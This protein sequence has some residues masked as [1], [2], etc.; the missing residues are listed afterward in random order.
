[1][2]KALQPPSASASRFHRFQAA[3]VTAIPGRAVTH[4]CQG[5]AGAG[6]AEKGLSS[7]AGSSLPSTGGQR[8]AARGGGCGERGCRRFVWAGSPHVPPAGPCEPP[9]LCR[10]VW[11]AVSPHG[12]GS[13]RGL[14]RSQHCSPL[15]LY[16]PLPAA[17]HQFA[18]T[19]DCELLV[20]VQG[21]SC[22]PPACPCP[23]CPAWSGGLFWPM[24]CQESPR[25]C[26]WLSSTQ[27]QRAQLGGGEMGLQPGLGS[28]TPGPLPG[29]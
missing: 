3:G 29:S 6:D 10:R 21:G 11:G 17:S 22:A 24:A 2:L 27:G 12:W 13:S 9:Q 4:T 16:L 18:F 14:P 20:W 19:A 28:G 23:S 26:P 8:A 5:P 1:M 15:R 7:L 25:P